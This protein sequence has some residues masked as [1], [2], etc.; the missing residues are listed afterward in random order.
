MKCINKGAEPQAFTDWKA[1]ANDDWQPTYDDLR[2]EPKRAVKQALMVEQ[3]Y[4]CCYCERRLEDS[5]SHIE[6][7]QPQHDPAVD[8]LDFS[9]LLCSCQNQIKK[10]E[11]RHCGNLKDEW[12][13]PA[14]IVSPFDAGCEARFAFN[15][16]GHIK[17]AN[18]S[19]EGA[20][21]MI[22][23]LGLDIPK[24]NALRE[25]AI[26]PFLDDSLSDEDMQAF[27]TGYLHRD[28]AGRF[29]PFW[30]TVHHLFGGY[31]TA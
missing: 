16:D 20:K 17:P 11:P 18:S 25:S 23:R 9:N 29:S 10:G 24:L 22:D 27:V 31:A 5:D 26:E 6:H 21:E 1:L 4:I 30:S 14:L 8:A 19:D 3:G 13:D 12:F 28:G 2:G 15:G 7:F